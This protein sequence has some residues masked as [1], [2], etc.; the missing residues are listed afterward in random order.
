MMFKLAWAPRKKSK[1]GALG[2]DIATIQLENLLRSFCQSCTRWGVCVWEN[3]QH[4]PLAC[5]NTKVGLRASKLWRLPMAFGTAITLTSLKKIIRV[6][7]RAEGATN[8]P[9]PGRVQRWFH[10][11]PNK[12]TTILWSSWSDS[13]RFERASCDNVLRYTCQAKETKKNKKRWEW[14]LTNVSKRDE[15]RCNAV[16]RHSS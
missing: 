5:G 9:C 8:L 11:A 12:T 10:C 7:A 2:F 15:Q 13:N 14:E 16:H 6:S 3:F 4:L 1:V